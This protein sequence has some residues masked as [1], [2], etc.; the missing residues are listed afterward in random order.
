MICC[1]RLWVAGWS[2]RCVAVVEVG[3]RLLR[4]H[5]RRC[6]TQIVLLRLALPKRLHLLE[7]ALQR[8]RLPGASLPN[9]SAVFFYYFLHRLYLS[10]V[11]R[12]EV[13]VIIGKSHE[14]LELFFVPRGHPFI[15]VTAS[16]SGLMPPA[17]TTRPRIFVS[18]RMKSHFSARILKPASLRHS[19][20]SFIRAIWSSIVSLAMTMSS[21]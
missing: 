6:P 16:G 13:A 8:R 11:E 2:F 3:C 14:A 21:M 18:V 20:T 17:D 19:N 4:L 9:G 12:N 7:P 10:C 15:L 1:R 5:W